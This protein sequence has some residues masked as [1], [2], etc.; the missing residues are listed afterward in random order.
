MI[1]PSDV[2][3]YYEDL[4][5]D[6]RMTVTFQVGDGGNHDIDFKIYDP[7]D[8]ILVDVTKRTDGEYNTVAVLDGR[9]TYCFSNE[10]STV[11]EKEISFNV[12]GIVYVPDDGS[13]TDSLEHEIRT[14]AEQLQLVKDEQEY[15]VQRE[16]R[17]RNT[18]ESTNTRVK[19][20][21][22]IQ[23]LIVVAVVGWQIFYLTRSV[24]QRSIKRLLIPFQLL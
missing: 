16:K 15:L 7:A 4:H 3:C 14:L 10:M 6:D 12:H 5:K 11:T 2:A 13:H 19:W 21:S 9:H 22:I 17:H 18:A 23:G 8:R 1:A 24:R 20:W